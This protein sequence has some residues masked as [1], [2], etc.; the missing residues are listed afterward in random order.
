[1]G[2]ANAG[3]AA[4][5]ENA[6]TEFFNPAGMSQLKG[7]NLSFGV[8]VLDIDVEAKDGSTS[9]T[10]FELKGE[11]EITNFPLPTLAY[12]AGKATAA[13]YPRL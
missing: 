12:L 8:A 1:M 4:N 2:V 6:S 11:A 9:A 10:E 3:A 13:R 5:P 7:T